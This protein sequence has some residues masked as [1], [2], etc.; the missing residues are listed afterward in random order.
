[1]ADLAELELRIK[2][3]QVAEANRRLKELQSGGAKAEKVAGRVEKS[4]D[5]TNRS[6]GRLKAGL[7]RVGLSL[8]AIAGGFT[9]IAGARKAV[10]VIADF[11]ESMATL[12]GVAIDTNDA[13]SVQNEQFAALSETAR[14]LGATTRFTASEAGEGLLF[15]ARAGFEANE[16]IAALPA[17]LDLASAG[18]LELGV[19]A[20]IASNVLSQF[21]LNA[22]ETTR[23]VDTLVKTANSANTDIRQLAEA[24]KLAGPLAGSLGLTVEETSAALGK[25]GD[26]GIQASL[27]GTNLRGIMAALLGPT[28]EATARI[29]QMGLTLN[30][31]DPSLNSIVDIFKRFR[32]AGLDAGS[33]LDI[34]GR[35]NVSAALV[36]RN[37]ADEMENLTQEIEKADGI[38]KQQAETVENTLAGSYRSLRSALEGATLA[39]GDKG[40]LGG[41]RTLVDFGTDVVRRLAGINAEIKTSAVLVRGLAAALEGLAAAGVAAAVGGLVNVFLQ[42]GKAIFAAR[43]GMV[44]LSLVTVQLF[45]VLRAHPIL[46][47]AS[48]VGAAVAAFSFF[49]TKVR[50]STIEVEDFDVTVSKLS[51]RFNAYSAEIEES[52]KRI[53]ELGKEM[54]RL[55]ESA[56]RDIDNI[57]AAMDRFGRPINDQIAKTRELADVMR[58]Q[59]DEQERLAELRSSQGT[60][61]AQR[62]QLRFAET[63]EAANKRFI[64]RI[65]LTDELTNRID[66]LRSELAGARR[67][68]RELSEATGVTAEALRDAA[69]RVKNYEDQLKALNDQQQK[70]AVSTKDLP[71]GIEDIVKAIEFEAQTLELSDEARQR[72]IDLMEIERLSAGLTAEEIAVIKGEYGLAADAID[73]Y[74]RKVEESAEKQRRAVETQRQAARV[75]QEAARGFKQASDFLSGSFTDAASDILLQIS[76]LE[77]AF[78]NLFETIIQQVLRVQLQNL[79]SGALSGAGGTGLGGIL[80]SLFVPANTTPSAAGNIF[81]GG[82]QVEQFQRGGIL[83]GPTAFGVGPGRIAIAG[84]AGPEVAF[85]PLA[86][87][88][89]GK[90]GVEAV[91]GGGSTSVTNNNV[92]MNIRTPDADSFRKS[93]RQIFEDARGGFSG[94]R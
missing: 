80:Q 11:E 86:R 16:A 30:E 12:R 89:T 31:I 19:A 56:T 81:S 29:R 70:T 90:L 63:V 17:T 93:R 25:L 21:S 40:L 22:E 35:R 68:E 53:I 18:Q 61:A 71:K 9:A 64:A 15:L 34:F 10:G 46:L 51:R 84:E 78:R 4:F 45:K 27:A 73:E 88:P 94:L 74:N 92:T 82:V 69:L 79:F 59:A 48:A 38:A 72:R 13:L 54:D 65:G 85:A 41:L 23:V 67:N 26:S 2:S 7:A 43:M 62:S 28:G 3:L 58:E 76:T 37:S 44:G 36:L 47:I 39:V 75:A 8:G 24:M 91:G 60:I 20:D 52:E 32:A 5:R 57:V 77:E 49:R 1:M 83:G 50:E 55:D 66:Q 14:T 42:L 6:A 87:G 33:A